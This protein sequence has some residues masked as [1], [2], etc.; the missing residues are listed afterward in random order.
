MGG[1]GPAGVRNAVFLKE[2]RL[3]L[4]LLDTLN[5]A[6]AVG[7]GSLLEKVNPLVVCICFLLGVSSCHDQKLEMKSDMGMLSE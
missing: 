4:L 3:S 5:L 1:G 6:S 2:C 7:P